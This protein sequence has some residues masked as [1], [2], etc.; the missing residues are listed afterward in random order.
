LSITARWVMTAMASMVTWQWVHCS[1]SR[2]NVLRSKSAHGTYEV[3]VRERGRGEGAA[4]SCWPGA[5]A[6][7]GALSEAGSLGAA[8]GPRGHSRRGSAT[9]P[10]RSALASS[11]RRSARSVAPVRSEDA[12]SSARAFR[13]PCDRARRSSP[14][15]AARNRRA[16]RPTGCSCFAPPAALRRRNPG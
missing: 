7:T 13:V 10:A 12:C 2:P 14:P 15:H 6:A 4:P 8:M 11:S 5:A 3:E 1:T 16:R 9:G